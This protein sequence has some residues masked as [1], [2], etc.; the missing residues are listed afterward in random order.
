MTKIQLSF[1]IVLIST[2]FS[3]G[4]AYE[5]GIQAGGGN[6]I[7]DIGREY[8]FYPNKI[9]GGILFKRTVNPWFSLRLN[10]NYYQIRANDAEA[11]SLGRQLRNFSVEGQIIN[12]SAGIEY[13]FIPRN[14]YLP[15]KS[16]H[17][18]SPYMF[19]GLG[20]GSYSG[21]IYSNNIPHTNHP[22]DYG[23]E[24]SGA[25]LNIP[26]K[27]GIKYKVSRHFILS[28]ESGVSYFF[29]DDLD[30]T[31]ALYDNEAYLIKNKIVPSTNT[32]SNDWYSFSSIGFIYTFG[33]LNCYFNL[34]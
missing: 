28:L 26:M 17:R 7:G 25:R 12:F 10:L 24:Y 16:L 1:I 9:G 3:Y 14:P 27:L 31:H 13:N 19:L 18:I 20:L 22:E 21:R 11:E 4:Q 5:F 30:G 6:Y 32:N 34:F 33:D 2:V 15:L 29:T 8:Y 23:L